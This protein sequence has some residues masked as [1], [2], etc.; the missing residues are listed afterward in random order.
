MTTRA[1]FLVV[2]AHPDDAEV[3]MGGTIVKLV[4]KG[5]RGVL[6]DM[7]DGEPSDF[8]APGERRAQAERAAEVLGVERILLG[9]QDRFIQDTPDQRMAVARVIRELRPRLV[10]S[11][12]AACVHPDHAAMDPLSRAAVF[13]ARLKHWDRVPGGEALVGTEPW[14]VERLFFP[15]CKLEPVW[16]DFA[17]AVDVSDVYQLKQQALYEY[18]SIFRV[19]E[20]DRLLELYEAEDAH[21]GRLLG[22]AYAE[23]F[24]SHSPLAVE[25]PTVFLPGIHA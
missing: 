19:D 25:D 24:R 11:T 17:F 21:M 16:S 7:C 6:L 8:D 9:F 1:D 4:R 20:G 23:T 15:H 14:E 2:S 5:L 12:A 18:R 10:F 3:Q 13:Y 22:V